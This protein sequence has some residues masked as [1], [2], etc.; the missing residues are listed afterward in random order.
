MMWFMVSAL[1]SIVLNLKNNNKNNNK[2]TEWDPEYWVPEENALYESHGTAG[3][4][5]CTTY[6]NS[7]CGIRSV[8]GKREEA[9]L[10]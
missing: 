8:G 9:A 1:L 5:W 6:W 3:P 7:Y 2:K 4:T 10:E